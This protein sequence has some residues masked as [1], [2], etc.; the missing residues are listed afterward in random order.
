VISH[1]TVA[2]DISQPRD[3]GVLAVELARL[4]KRVAA[5]EKAAYSEPSAYVE[6]WTRAA[7]V[8]GVHERTCKYRAARGQFPRP[9]RTITI[10]RADGKDHERPVWRREELIAYG[11]GK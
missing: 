11:E 10:E 8:V 6:G 9:C 5:L 7:K 4:E 1:G 2:K 3:V